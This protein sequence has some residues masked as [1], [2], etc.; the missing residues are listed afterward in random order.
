MQFDRRLVLRGLAACTCGH[1]LALP[2]NAQPRPGAR[3]AAGGCNIAV[4]DTTKYMGF[5]VADSNLKEVERQFVEAAR[6]NAVPIAAQGPAPPRNVR[7]SSLGKAIQR[8]ATA[9]E[10]APPFAFYDDPKHI[11]AKAIVP[12]ALHPEGGVIFE[13]QLFAQLLQSDPSGVAILGVLAHEYGHM[14]MYQRAELYH[15]L[16]NFPTVMRIEL[17]ADYLAGYYLGVRKREVPSVSLFKAGAVTWNV[18]DSGFNDPAHHGGPVDRTRAA[19]AGF[20]LGYRVA[21]SFKQAFDY[22]T[23]FV[24][25]SYEN[26]PR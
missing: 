10:V 21:P 26:D 1:R 9:F 14:A 16:Q 3:A 18:G 8:L 25:V 19:E 17:H 23:H 7:A 5:R 4:G 22:A 12:T 13:R 24:T 15:Q 11:N 6:L 20:L 2:A